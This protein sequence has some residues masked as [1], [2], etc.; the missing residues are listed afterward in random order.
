MAASVFATQNNH[1]KTNKNEGK[2]RSNVRQV[3]QRTDVSKHCD[4]ADGNAG[5]DRRDVRCA[6]SAVNPRKIL[7]QQTVARHG[8]KNARLPELENQY[9]RRKTS[10]RAS[11]DERLRPRPASECCGDRRRITE[12]RRIYSHSGDD[13][14]HQHIQ[15]CTNNQARDDSDRHVALRIFCFFRGSRDGVESDERKKD[16]GR[17]AHHAAYA[18]GQKRVPISGVHHERTKRDYEDNDRYLGNDNGSICARALPNPVDQKDGHRCNN[19]NRG[20]V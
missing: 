8:H 12:I 11:A 18:V 5:P 17:T 14:C 9:H 7:W 10:K 15:Q 6:E 20:Q 3:G 13:G 4:T 1:T 2:Q 16:D 19:Q